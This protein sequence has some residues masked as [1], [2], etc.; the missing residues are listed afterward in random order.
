M[1][2]MI[3]GDAPLTACHAAAQVHIVQRP[4]LVLQ[5]R[6]GPGGCL[7][8]VENCSSVAARRR[9]GRKGGVIF[10]LKTIP[11]DTRPALPAS[12][13]PR[14]PPAREETHSQE[15]VARHTPGSSEADNEFEW[16][17]PD[18]SKR[19]AF[20]RDWGDVLLLAAEHD[21]CLAGACWERARGKASRSLGAA[22]LPCHRQRHVCTCRLGAPSPRAP[23][24]HCPRRRARAR[25]GGGPGA[26]GHPPRPGLRARVPRAEGVDPQDPPRARLH[27]TD[28]RRRHQRRGGPQGG[29]RRRR[30]ARRA[31]GGAAC[32]RGA[33]RGREKEGQEERRRRGRQ[34]RGRRQEGRRRQGQG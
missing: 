21:L 19:A 33:R 12:H 25:R 28:G 32:G 4:V 5:H 34:R 17:A 3:T 31:A 30:A 27:D 11:P 8:L 6:C 1:L 2:V 22:V 10:Q 24:P 20:S 29:A 14:A 15:A 16:V 13:P 9:S 26:Q 18:E 7:D 23:H